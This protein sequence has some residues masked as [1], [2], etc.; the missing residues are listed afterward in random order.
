MFQGYSR[1]AGVFLP[2]V[3][4]LLLPLSF[5]GCGNIANLDRKIV[6]E[7]RGENIRRADLRQTIYDMTDEERPLIQNRQDL[8]DALNGH[9]DEEIKADLAKKLRKSKELTVQREQARMIYFAK[10]PEYL[11]LDK[12]TDPSIMGFSKR[13]LRALQAEIEF[14]IDDEMELLYREAAVRYHIQKLIDAG[15]IKID[16][17]Q[18]AVEYE[19]RKSSL[20]TFEFIDFIGVRIP[21]GTGAREDIIQARRRLDEG[22]PILTVV[23]SYIER[24]RAF[25]MRAAFENNPSKVH[26]RPFWFNVTGCKTGDVL[27]PLLLPAYEEQSAGS[28][29]EMVAVSQPE[30]WVVFEV[31]E[32]QDRREMTLEEA[33]S[34]LAIPI[35]RQ[36]VMDRF[37][38][39]YGVVIYPDNLWYPEGI[40][41]Q[42]KDFM[43]VTKS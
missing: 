28:N 40:G 9:I 10:N 6:A 42:Y 8:L 14:G 38:E 23:E 17:N 31:Q 2:V 27:G 41:D 5:T 43:I 36:R 19:R 24:D 16:D 35:L 22:E 32:H 39:E 25:G 11:D 7:F 33:K 4:A 26:F 34:V 12:I 1:R 37:R 18:F 30:S 21:N 13:D 20:Y 3:V 15:N 29:G